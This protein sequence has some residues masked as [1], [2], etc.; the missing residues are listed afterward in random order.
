[1]GVF[2]KSSERL[3]W[4]AA[5]DSCF[6]II[7]DFGHG[8]NY[9]LP[10]IKKSCT[11]IVMRYQPQSHDFSQLCV[12]IM[13]HLYKNNDEDRFWMSVSSNALIDLTKF[14]F[15]NLLSTMFKLNYRELKSEILK[16]WFISTN[17]QIMYAELN[18]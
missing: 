7:T 14:F 13:I 2:D 8:T 10:N 5:A 16:H 6:C 9:A 1:M 15:E 11:L 18:K 3:I 4:R 17:I 12:Y